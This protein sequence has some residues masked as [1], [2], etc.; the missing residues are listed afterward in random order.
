MFTPIQVNIG[1]GMASLLSQRLGR[2]TDSPG[3]LQQAMSDVI[4]THTRLRQAV[5]DA[6]GSRNDFVRAMDLLTANLTTK[7]EIRD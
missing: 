5:N 3:K 2:E 1:S 6:A 7:A 4:L